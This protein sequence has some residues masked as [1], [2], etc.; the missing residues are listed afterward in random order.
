[1]RLESF[2]AEFTTILDRQE[3]EAIVQSRKANKRRR[4]T[5]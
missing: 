5:D 3:Q 1:M 4:A 2:V